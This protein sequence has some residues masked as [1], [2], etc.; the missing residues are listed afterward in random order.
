[1]RER[2]SAHQFTG[3]CVQEPT[4]TLEVISFSHCITIEN[5]TKKGVA[6][7]LSVC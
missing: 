2:S 7:G 5:P 3:L 4:Q 1:M 6:F